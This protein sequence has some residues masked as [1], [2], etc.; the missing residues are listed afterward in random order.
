MLVVY[1]FNNDAAPTDVDRHLARVSI[2]RAARTDVRAIG[3]YDVG[4]KRAK[5]RRVVRYGRPAESAGD[6]IDGKRTRTGETIHRVQRGSRTSVRSTA[7]LKASWAGSMPL[8]E[9]D[10]RQDR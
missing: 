4:S 1:F 6:R 3:N 8:V 2:V 9:P 7:R 10:Q 5:I